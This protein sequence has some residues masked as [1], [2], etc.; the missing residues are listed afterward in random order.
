MLIATTVWWGL[1]FPLTKDWQNAGEQNIVGA[2]L[3][4]FTVIVLRMAIAVLILAIFTPRNVISATRREHVAGVLLGS[5][6]FVG[7]ALQVLGLLYTTP[8]GSAF[9]TSLSSVW[10]PLFAWLC[11]GL[12]V[13]G[14]TVFGLALGLMGTFV[15]SM[16]GID[17]VHWGIGEGLTILCTLVFA[18]QI[19]LLDRIGRGLN[20]A[21]ITA[22]Y[23]AT[24]GIAS[25][26]CAIAIAWNGPGIR[27]WMEC[28]WDCPSFAPFS[29]FT[30]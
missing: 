27:A 12:R 19:L 9:I 26:V 16:G 14:L 20:S 6:T 17:Q 25:L 11:F 7:W 30:G 28:C 18:V 29:H 22:T 21:H 5:V 10:V 8:A 1:S 15:L 3:A 2:P 13:A 23:L 4:S 24:G